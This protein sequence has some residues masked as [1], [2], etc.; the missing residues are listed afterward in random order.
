MGFQRPRSLVIC[1]GCLFFFIRLVIDEGAI[2]M[3]RG[4]IRELPDF[5]PYGSETNYGVADQLKGKDSLMSH[6]K[7]RGY[8]SIKQIY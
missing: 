7:Y 5:K 3:A 8:I 2:T 4:G 1:N 6:L